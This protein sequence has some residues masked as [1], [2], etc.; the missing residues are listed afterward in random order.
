M[1]EKLTATSVHLWFANFVEAL[2]ATGRVA[3]RLVPQPQP[4]ELTA[5][6]H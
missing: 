1:M 2:E 4:V 5:K 6:S 3:P